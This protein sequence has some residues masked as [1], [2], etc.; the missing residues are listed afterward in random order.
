[1]NGPRR[2]RLRLCATRFVRRARMA[3]LQAAH[4]VIQ[5]SIFD[6]WRDRRQPALKP[7]PRCSIAMEITADKAHVALAQRAYGSAPGIAAEALKS[8][9]DE[10][11]SGAARCQLLKRIGVPK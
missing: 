8:R 7:G 11:L 9:C 2:G 1:V 4:E 10:Y 6:A 3:H 5:R